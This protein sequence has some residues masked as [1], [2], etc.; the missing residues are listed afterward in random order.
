LVALNLAFFC[1]TTSTGSRQVLKAQ[2]EFNAEEKRILDLLGRGLSRDFPNPQRVGCPGSAVLRGI[3]LHKVPLSEADR[4]LDHFSSC[5]PCFQEFTQ[6][7]KQ[8]VNR[9]RSQ[10]WLAVA[11]VFLFAVAGWFWV[12]T[13]PQVQTAVIVVLDLRGRATVR[14]ENPPETSQSQ[15]EVPRSAKSLN[16]ELPIGSNEGA[17]EV[18]LL[19]PSG[20]ELLRTNATAKLEDHIVV[21]RADVDL[22]VISPGSYFLGLRQRGLEWMR[23]PIRVL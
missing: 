11:A 17:Y 13:R 7:R 16:L 20:T 6:F 23:F 22:A 21:L 1:E 14:G 10:I 2:E 4:W 3:A 8:A 12:R 19:D 18:A 5:S 15:L 9:R